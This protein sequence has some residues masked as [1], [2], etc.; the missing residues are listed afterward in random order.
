MPLRI[1]VVLCLALEITRYSFAATDN[2]TEIINRRTELFDELEQKD[3]VLD[4]LESKLK[5]ARDKKKKR[6]D[7]LQKDTG[8]KRGNCGTFPNNVDLNIRAK[9][10][11][12]VGDSETGLKFGESGK[13]FLSLNSSGVANVG[14]ANLQLNTSDGAL[15]IP[16]EDLFIG[17]AQLDCKE[18]QDSSSSGDLKN[19]TFETRRKGAND[20]SFTL[21]ND[22]NATSVAAV[23][24]TTLPAVDKNDLDDDV[25]EA[26]STTVAPLLNAT[27]ATTTTPKPK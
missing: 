11:A 1:S 2:I 17:R 18:P 15:N 26:K 21:S 6:T 20:T 16:L 8:S 4:M 10:I 25:I 27:M 24:N 12:V 13:N 3:V 7:H 5:E 22:V 19:D 23:G 14:R 9:G